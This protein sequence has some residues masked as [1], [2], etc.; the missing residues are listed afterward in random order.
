MNKT[1]IDVVN[2]QNYYNNNQAMTVNLND[3]QM[4]VLPAPLS[5]QTTL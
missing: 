4:V 2:N 3:Q 5:Y 1:I